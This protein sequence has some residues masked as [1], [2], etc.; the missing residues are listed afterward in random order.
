[1]V[2]SLNKSII[3]IV[4]V[5]NRQNFNEVFPG[6]NFKE[7]LPELPMDENGHPTV[8]YENYLT[9]FNELIEMNPENEI[10]FYQNIF[11]KSSLNLIHV[12]ETLCNLDISS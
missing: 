3:K 5:L 6:Y 2:E 8:N 9:N 4:E 1:M 7:I 11:S 12:F 10:V